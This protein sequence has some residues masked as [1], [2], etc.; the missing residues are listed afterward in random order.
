MYIFKKKIIF[1][2]ILKKIKDNSYVLEINQK[3]IEN[4][5]LEKNYQEINKSVDKIL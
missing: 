1:K 3:I 4:Y 2:L 5:C